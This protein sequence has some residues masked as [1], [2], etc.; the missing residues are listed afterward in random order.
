ML[1]LGTWSGLASISGVTF[2]S[3]ISRITL[4]A[5]PSG[6][7]CVSPVPRLAWIARLSLHAGVPLRATWP[8]RSR[9]S[10]LRLSCRCCLCRRC[11]ATGTEQHDRD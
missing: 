1:S 2:L 7:A 11:L 3:L 4:V 9:G 8:G 6:V 5:G 10:R